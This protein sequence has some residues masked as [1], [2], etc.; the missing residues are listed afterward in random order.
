MGEHKGHGNKAPN[1]PDLDE[2]GQPGSRAGANAG[3]GQNVGS[4]GGMQNQG[5]QQSGKQQDIDQQTLDKQ[6]IGQQGGRKQE[7]KQQQDTGSQQGAGSQRQNQQRGGQQAT[8][9]TPSLDDLNADRDSRDQGSS[10]SASRQMD[11]Q[12]D[13]EGKQGK[14]R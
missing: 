10:G 4:Q 14:N 12:S 1:Y 2:S 3:K 8:G 13:W 9:G 5:S 7:G 11:Q 6:S